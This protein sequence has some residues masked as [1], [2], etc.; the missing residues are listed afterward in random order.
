M[1]LV[2]IE[3][4]EVL[5]GPQGTLYGSGSMGGTVRTIP[6]APDLTQVDGRLATR[7]SQTANNGSSNNMVQGVLNVP[8][9]SDELAVRAVAYHFDNSGYIKNIAASNTNLPILNDGIALGG[10]A[11]DR[12]DIGAEKYKGFRV[13]ALWQATDQLAISLAYSQQK[14]EQNGF[15]EVNLGLPGDFEQIRLDVGPQGDSRGEFMESEVDLTNLV[16]D[17]DLGWGSI[18]SSSS[19]INYNVD[20]AI[21]ASPVFL[22]P[23]FI[24]ASDQTD[25]FMEELRFSSK[26]T[27]PFQILAGIY[28]EDRESDGTQGF[29]WSGNPADD[30]GIDTDFFIYEATTQ[31]AFFAEMSYQLSEQWEATFGVRHFDYDLERRDS[32]IGALAEPATQSTLDDKGENFKVNLTYTPKDD[33]LIYGQWAEGFRQGK[34]NFAPSNCFQS[35][36]NILNDLGIEAQ[37]GVN[38]DSLENFEI[39]L[40]TSMLDGSM[41]LNAAVYRINWEGIPVALLETSCSQFFTF[42]AGES[43]SEGV[44]LA[45]QTKISS[46]LTLDISASYGEATLTEDAPNLGSKGDNLPGSADVNASVGLEH[47]FTLAGMDAFFRGDYIYIGEYF[48]NLAETGQASGGYGTT[49]LKLGV[50]IDAIDVDLYV[51][52]LS[53]ADDFTWLETV[54]PDFGIDRAYRL[55]PRTIGLN[56]GYN[57]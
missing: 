10:Q 16:I 6:N 50:T 23:L 45:L 57:F 25:A 11:N 8:L 38:S 27:G 15:P 29:T 19:W 37:D 43:K 32:G 40:K 12:D 1:K 14:I 28:Y 49:N 54:Y 41:I 21:D 35:G 47:K 20:N 56:I 7:Y 5:R 42:N 9:I 26:F 34:P 4:I 24:P 17:Y 44:E 30:F 39:G 2:D 48:H 51:Y 22:A 55:R 46:N 13:T 52:N 53:N 31:K 36:T 3:R 33:T 18:L